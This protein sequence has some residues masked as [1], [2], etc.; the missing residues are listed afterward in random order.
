MWHSILCHDSS[1]VWDLVPAHLVI[2]FAP[3]LMTPKTRVW[4]FWIVSYHCGDVVP[5]GQS[6][7]QSEHFWE[8][9]QMGSRVDGIRDLLH[10]VYNDQI[11]SPCWLHRGVDRDPNGADTD[12]QEML[13][14]AFWWV[15]NKGGSWRWPRFYVAFRLYFQDSIN[16]AKYESLVND[17]CIAIELSVCRLDIRG[18][19]NL[20]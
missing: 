5:P 1:Y 15:T 10:S 17:L 13:D 20:S 18:T 6:D 14:H 7:P 11:T 3:G 9:R 2:M 8:D 12:H 16:V 4:Q 19:L